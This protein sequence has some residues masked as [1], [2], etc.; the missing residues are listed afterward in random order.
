MNGNHRRSSNTI[1]F[2]SNSDTAFRKWSIMNKSNEEKNTDVAEPRE[3]ERK[4][5]ESNDKHEHEAFR[6]IQ[7]PI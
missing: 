6:W 4:K 5:T 1:P 7:F 2:G 3:R